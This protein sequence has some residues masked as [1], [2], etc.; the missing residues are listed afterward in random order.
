MELEEAPVTGGGRGSAL[1]LHRGRGLEAAGFVPSRVLHDKDSVGSVVSTGIAAGATGEMEDEEDEDEPAVIAAYW[2]S[3]SQAASTPNFS[4][5]MQK[6]IDTVGQAG[7][8]EEELCSRMVGKPLLLAYDASWSC[9]RFRYAIWK[10]VQRFVSHVAGMSEDMLSSDDEDEL[11][12]TSEQERR[13][14]MKELLEGDLKVST[15]A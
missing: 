8:K 11:K 9:A 10:Q 2:L 12:D 1:S 6:K 14:W 5:L 4:F 3:N 13:D 15:A 7:E